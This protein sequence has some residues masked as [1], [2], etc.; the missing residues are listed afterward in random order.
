MCSAKQKFATSNPLSLETK[1]GILSRKPISFRQG[2][3]T[4]IQFYINHLVMMTNI[5]TCTSFAV[6]LLQTAAANC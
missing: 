3:Y 6:A 1:P 5:N 4:D 2:P